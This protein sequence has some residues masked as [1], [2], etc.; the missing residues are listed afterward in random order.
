MAVG[1]TLLSSGLGGVFPP[2]LPVGEVASVSRPE[3]RLIQ[4]VLLETF[5][6]FF[7]LE[8]VFV[9]LPLA[10]PLVPGG[11]T[12]DSAEATAGEAGP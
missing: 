4:D 5:V 7:R 10:G 11:L 2:G 3:D 8:E 12:A 1:D 6:S 9:I